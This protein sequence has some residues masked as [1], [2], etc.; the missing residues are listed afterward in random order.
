VFSLRLP[1]V[2]SAGTWAWR[3]ND[4]TPVESARIKVVVK[5]DC[6]VKCF[7]EKLEVKVRRTAT[8]KHKSLD[9]GEFFS[10]REKNVK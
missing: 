7:S 2:K 5:N 1:N 8:I 10:G 6:G 3:S 9:W 4:G